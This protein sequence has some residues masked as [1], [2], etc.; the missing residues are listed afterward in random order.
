[1]NYFNILRFR[2]A[3]RIEQHGSKPVARNGIV[4]DLAAVSSGASFAALVPAA[5]SHC[6]NLSYK[7][8]IIA[9]V[10]RHTR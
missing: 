6:S 1:M 2:T 8:R 10:A 4:E 7:Q 9:V 3:P 5:K